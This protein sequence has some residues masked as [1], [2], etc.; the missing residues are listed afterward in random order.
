MSLRLEEIPTPGYERVVHAKDADTNL[1]AVISVHNTRLGPGLG[2]VR[3][4]PY[5]SLE[6]AVADANLLSKA[7]TYKAA[8]AATGQGGGKAVIIGDP[9]TKTEA[10]M[11]SMG[12][13][14]EALD[15]QYIAAED[16]NMTVA[17]LETIARETRWV[18][19]LSIDRGSSGDPSPQ[20][21]LGCLIAMR[22]T[23]H[24]AL[25][26]Q[27]LR[28]RSIAIQGVGAVGSALARLCIEDG[29]EVTL[30]D[31]DDAKAHRVAAEIGAR[32]LEGADACLQIPCDILSPCARGTLFDAHSIPTLQC[33]AI[34]GAANN[35][36]STPEAGDRLR[37]RGI[38]YAPDYVA[39]AGGIINIAC[40]FS[41][42]GYSLAVARKRV[43]SIGTALE[44]TFRLAESKNLSTAAA[45]DILAERRLAAGG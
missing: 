40:E 30:C 44:E 15:G 25:G 5:V 29:A 9:A 23:A 45:A 38:I 34:C 31:L 43:E 6:A 35:Q 12:R 22:V 41:A 8:I 27:N 28:G 4:L 17:D 39:N 36:L 1:D 24:E 13:F 20:T 33:K 7:M 16:M 3:M 18:S 42:E 26:D 10:M 19:G 37:E 14:I 32:A 2:G 21:A 11:L